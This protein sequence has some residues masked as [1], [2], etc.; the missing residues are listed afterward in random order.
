VYQVI[1]AFKR[2]AGVGEGA[3]P[4]E[5]SVRCGGITP[6]LPLA[7]RLQQREILRFFLQ[8]P[9]NKRLSILHSEKLKYRIVKLTC[10]MQNHLLCTN[11]FHILPPLVAAVRQTYRV[12]STSSFGGLRPSPRLGLF[13]IFSLSEA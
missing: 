4:V 2:I 12:S 1:V 11:G 9:E 13:L 8:L 5:P 10:T 7:L 3:F 6:E